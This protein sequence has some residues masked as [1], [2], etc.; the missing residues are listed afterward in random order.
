MQKLKAQIEETERMRRKKEKEARE[1]SLL[2][3]KLLKTIPLVNE[4]NAMADELGKGMVSGSSSCSAHGLHDDAR[5][6]RQSHW[7]A[8]TPRYRR[9]CSSRS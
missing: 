3:E 1:R 6:A 7:H 5:G 4:A 2:D 8:C 9:R